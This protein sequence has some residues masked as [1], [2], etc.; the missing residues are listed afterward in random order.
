MISIIKKTKALP[1]Q[2]ICNNQIKKENCLYAGCSGKQKW[3]RGNKE[4]YDKKNRQIIQKQSDKKVRNFFDCTYRD[5]KF[6]R[7]DRGSTFQ[8]LVN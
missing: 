1:K 6:Q 7:R 2:D 3:K 5:E 4:T 8:N